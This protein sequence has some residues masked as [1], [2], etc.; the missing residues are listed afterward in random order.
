MPILTVDAGVCGFVTAIR[1]SS[2]DQQ[3]VTLEFETTCPNLAK[4]RGE[5]PSVD[6]YAELFR[7]PH[8]TTVYAVLSKHLPHV[9]CPLYS[10]F[11]KAIEAAA[12]LALPR[13]VS[14][15]FQQG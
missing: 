10:G 15:K 11:L 8:E 3:T 4:A 6:A 14:M 5:L 12:G 1:T 2:E 13:D 9:T 7:K